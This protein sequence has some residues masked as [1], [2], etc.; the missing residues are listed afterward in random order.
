MNK[1]KKV[2]ILDRCAKCPYRY[3]D[4]NVV[5]GDMDICTKKDKSLDYWACRQRGEFPKGCPLPNYK[6]N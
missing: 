6:E 2:I 1:T 5:L 3:T 4:F